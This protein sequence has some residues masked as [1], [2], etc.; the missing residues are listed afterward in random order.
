M[1]DSE[2]ASD[3]IT[4]IIGGGSGRREIGSLRTVPGRNGSGSREGRER[5]V[6]LR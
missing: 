3:A 2:Q 4:E 5:Q 1:R 6:D